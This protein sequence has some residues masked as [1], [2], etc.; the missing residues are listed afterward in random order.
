M[1]KSCVSLHNMPRSPRRFINGR[2]PFVQLD[3]DHGDRVR[4]MPTILDAGSCA[5]GKATTNSADRSETF[6]VEHPERRADDSPHQTE[7]RT[8]LP[9]RTDKPFQAHRARDDHLRFPGIEST[10]QPC[11]VMACNPAAYA[12]APL[13]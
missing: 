8:M 12:I 1:T 3:G 13:R 6:V 4:F 5:A 2:A 7:L 10:R 11:R 9:M